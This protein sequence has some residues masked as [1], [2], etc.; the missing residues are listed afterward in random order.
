MD[1]TIVPRKRGRPRKII[2]SL[3]PA[4]PLD[5][6]TRP[7]S[8]AAAG[9]K[10]SAKLQK[11]PPKFATKAT[12]S[13]PAVKVS[14]PSS[15]APAPSSEPT[16]PRIATAATSDSKIL[17]EVAALKDGSSTAESDTKATEAVQR[18]PQEQV[19][20]G[21]HNSVRSS[22][23]SK[24]PA[25]GAST[26]TISPKQLNAFAVNSLSGRAH[27][28]RPSPKISDGKLPP[29]YKKVANKWVR[30]MVGLPIVFVTSYMLFDRC[31]L[32][33]SRDFW[34]GLINYMYSG[35][36]A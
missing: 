1:A 12:K 23:P 26:S 29:A 10:A 8:T 35:P 18:I 20:P 2:D 32:I 11:E 34:W 9:K 17:R 36:R 13:K 7:K 31:E 24:S 5:K 3:E 15:P 14:T 27:P 25:A 22:A 21:I 30:V 4:P 28:A 33:L 19:K 16:K 6:A